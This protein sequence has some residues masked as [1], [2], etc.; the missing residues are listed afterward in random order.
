MYDRLRNR[1]SILLALTL[2]IALSVSMLQAQDSP[3]VLQP[4]STV[5]GSLGGDVLAQVYTFSGGVGETVQI[6]LNTGPGV[7]I[8]LTDVSGEPLAR[9]TAGVGSGR[10]TIELPPVELDLNNNYYVTVFI[11]SDAFVAAEG[12]FELTLTN[13]ESTPDVAQTEVA[14]P[15][16]EVEATPVAE[17]TAEATA[18]VAASGYT[19]PT[20]IVTGSGLQV[21][22]TW[23]NSAD[24]NLQLRDPLDGDLFW[25]SRTTPSG[26]SFGFDANGLCEVLTTTPSETASYPGGSLSTGSYE[27]LV[28]YRASCQNEGA[29]AFTV[30]VVL[31][32][33]AQEPIQ[34]TL[35][36]PVGNEEQVF[37]SSFVINPNGTLTFGQT[38]VY[39]GNL[40]PS[41]QNL[42]PAVPVTF[43]TPVRGFITNTQ[44]YQTYTFTGLANQLVSISASQVAG[45]L[46]TLM[47][48]LGPSGNVVYTNDDVEFGVTNSALNNVRLPI[49]GQYTVVVSRYGQNLGGTEGEF[50]LLITGPSG[51]L[52]AEV[53]ALNLPEGDITVT[54]FWNTAADLQLLVRDPAGNSVFD[55]VPNVPSGGRLVAAGNVNCT[56]TQTQP[57][58]YI[59][60]P[61][62]FLRAG[63]YEVDVWYQNDCGDNTPVDFTVVVEV[64]GNIIFT[65][66]V[67]PLPGNQYV[68]SFN[69]DV[70][71]QVTVYGGGVMSE[72]M[73]DYQTQL[74]DAPTLLTGQPQRGSLSFENPFDVYVF[75][76]QEGQVVN[77]GLN[78]ISGNL[79]TL[80]YV[81]DPNGNLL[82]SNDDAVAG[83]VTNSLVSNLTLAF[84]GQYII[85]ATRFGILYGATTGSYEMVLTL[86]G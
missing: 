28:Y 82:V 6:S 4:N 79:D 86:Q 34:G 73:I 46:D 23:N 39:T 41:A 16:A 32:G 1:A 85:L 19:A 29:T 78:Q 70:N 75:E 50:D 48:L 71:R 44:P 60:W 49:E 66:T 27:I 67:R 56:Q 14:E 81:L 38:G 77:I 63:T 20:Q 61:Q 57:V 35:L 80:L 55:D 22:L 76:G 45:S 51:D 33:V 40:G 2:L 58:S 64:D 52:P 62:G 65:D 83:E 36:P 31:D 5:S 69:V 17:A 43:D 68:S 10:R 24:L 25:D 30:N 59:Y 84:D 9:S 12:D 18:P 15:T 72:R 11:Y 37:L 3:R 7:A 54:L 8:L 74:A 47:F 53:L 26:G 13:L 21:T 42:P